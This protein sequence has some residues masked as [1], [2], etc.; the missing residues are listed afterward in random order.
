LIWGPGDETIL[1]NL[2]E[3]VDAGRYRWIDGGNW[4]TS[5]CH[6]SNLVEAIVLAMDRGE[7]GQ[8]YFITDEEVHSV[9]DFLSQLLA[10]AHRDPG[11][12]SVP[13]W[14]VRFLGQFFEAIWRL[15]R[16]KK[17]P[18]ITRFSAAIMSAHCT[19]S[20]DKANRELGYR[21]IISVKDG[22][23]ELASSKKG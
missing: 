22:M 2:I 20:S 6:I 23:K 3:M 5:T 8:V 17:K 9:R 11:N 15:F 14:L 1:A 18:P 16:I 19:I 10:T 7:G 13:S 4:N 12:K 21:P